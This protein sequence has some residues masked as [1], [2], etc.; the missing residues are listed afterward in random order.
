MVSVE[1]DYKTLTIDGKTITCPWYP[2]DIEIIGDIVVVQQDSSVL[3]KSTRH[4]DSDFQLPTEH[5]NVLA[6]ND[7]AEVLWFV[8]GFPDFEDDPGY[9]REL[10]G[11]Q[12]YLLARHS[13]NYFDQID[14]ETGRVVYSFPRYKLPIGDDFVIFDGEVSSIVELDDKIFVG[15][16]KSDHD[17]YAFDADG[18]ELWRSK[19]GK[20]RGYIYEEDGEL[21]EDVATSHNRRDL[22]RID[23]ETGDRIDHRSDPNA[24][25]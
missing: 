9:Y 15:C 4:E 12:D 14:V 17:I 16:A 25:P 23:P 24:R 10:F 19:H 1:S 18:T 7:S 8:E 22:Y 3:D 21:W 2:K 5:R 11:Y 20:R 6:L 13:H